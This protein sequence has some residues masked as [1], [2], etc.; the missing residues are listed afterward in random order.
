[1]NNEQNIGGNNNLVQNPVQGNNSG[2]D[3]FNNSASTVTVNDGVIPVQPIFGTTENSSNVI[4]NGLS[5]ATVVMNNST[6]E[7]NNQNVN[8]ESVSP[9]DIGLGTTNNVSGIQTNSTTMSVDN[10]INQNVNM[11]MQ[12]ESNN[13]NNDIKQPDS[14][15][16]ENL[17]NNQVSTLNNNQDNNKLD[18][19][20]NIVSVWKYLGHIL[21]FSIPLVGI[22]MLFVKAFGDK[23]D[24]NISNF[25][26][27]QLILCAIGVV[28]AIIFMIISFAAVGSMINNINDNANSYIDY[29]DYTYDY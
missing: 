6:P 12:D 19:S 4:N 5:E 27:A 20:D 15:V 25:A 23:K 22:I 3:I 9:F 1:M 17:G 16:S 26:K 10:N 2:V 8:V 29:N 28:V 7:V 24:K 21:L 18:N 14:L 13:V 11:V